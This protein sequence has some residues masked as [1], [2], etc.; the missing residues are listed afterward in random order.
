MSDEKGP[1]LNVLCVPCEDPN[2][3]H[4]EDLDDMPRQLLDEITHFF[5]VYKNLEGHEVTIEGWSPPE[6]ALAIIEAS[7]ERYRSRGS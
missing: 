5:S 3:K 7:R 4:V 1:D 6:D 2:W